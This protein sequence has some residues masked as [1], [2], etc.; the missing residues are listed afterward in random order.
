M[1]NYQAL[2][3][4]PKPE[5]INKGLTPM[6]TSKLIALFGRPREVITSIGKPVT[7]FV[8][9]K[10]MKTESVGKFR[11][12]GMDVALDSLRE[13]LDEIKEDN[14]VLYDMIGTAGMLC[15]RT[16]R[17][18]SSILSNH[19]FGLAIDLT[20]GG[21][22]D[23][24]GDGR[25]QGGLLAVYPYFHKHGWYWGAEYPTEDGMH[26]EMSWEKFKE[27]ARKKGVKI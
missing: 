26:F 21:R 18:S 24:R 1:K 14:P 10:M 27:L 17:G 4:R 20:I 22:L 19:A 2:Y 25:V 11:A 8:L 23:V 5:D 9:Q 7:N 15:V 12:T 13:V 6:N 3:P 16:V